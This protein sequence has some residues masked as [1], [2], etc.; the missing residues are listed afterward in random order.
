MVTTGSDVDC[1]DF[2]DMN[3]DFFPIVHRNSITGVVLGERDSSNCAIRYGYETIH[4]TV[5]SNC[6]T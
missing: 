1:L 5:A 3:L 2:M 6:H 4:L